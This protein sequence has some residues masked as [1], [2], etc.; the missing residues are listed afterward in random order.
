MRLDQRADKAR[1][2]DAV[3]AHVHGRALAGAV[4]HL[5]AHRFGVFG[6]EVEDLPDL[7][8]AA[9]H[10]ALLGDL[11]EELRFVG[12][13]R[14][15]VE[16]GEFVADRL[17]PRLVV[18]I[19]GPVAQGQR[20]DVL[21]IEHFGFAGFRQHQKFM[22]VVAADRAAVGAHRD[23]LQAHAL[24]GAQVSD[25]VAVVG[26]HRVFD[27]QVEVVAVLH[28]EFAAA[29]HAE[30]GAG[31]VPEFPLDVIERQRQRLVAF[32]MAAE[33]VGDHLLVRGAVEHVAL[34]AVADAQQLF[35][36]GVVAAGFAPQIRGLKRGHQHGDVPGAG[37]FFVHDLFDLAEHLVAQR[38]PGI[39]PRARLF[40]HARAQ[41]QPVADDLRFG[42][43]FLEDGQEIAGQAHGMVSPWR[44]RGGA[45]PALQ[46]GL[47]EGAG[48]RNR[49][50]RPGAGFGRDSRRG[51][52]AGAGAM[53]DGFA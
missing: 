34:V 33:D 45:A 50:S 39:D 53:H 3:A 44:R 25:H 12:F 35:A 11:G 38:Q 52:G 26:V 40:D 14:A 9:L 23:R 46:S 42:G 27:R 31:L 15:R 19:D 18:E 41:H 4:D 10:A 43:V 28:Q 48:P 24:I 36:I 16:G 8:A 5:G 2:A 21:V 22:G 37:L 30:A 47:A 51:R 17:D 49:A 1:H 13:V 29:H 32:D 6:A 7:D 20:L